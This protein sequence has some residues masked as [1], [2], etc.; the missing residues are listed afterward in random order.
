MFKTLMMVFLMTT[1]LCA[2]N[3]RTTT[4]V[5]GGISHGDYELTIGNHE[6]S[7]MPNQYGG[8]S[9]VTLWNAAASDDEG[10][11]YMPHMR[12]YEVRLKSKAGVRS[13]AK[14]VIDG[15]EVGVFRVEP[16]QTIVIERSLGDTARFTFIQKQTREY[17]AAKLDQVESG[18][19]GLISVTFTPERGYGQSVPANKPKI[20][21]PKRV[22]E[23]G[24]LKT[25]A[26]SGGTGLTGQSNQQFNYVQGIQYDQG[27]QVT[28]HLRLVPKETVEA[29]VLK[30]LEASKP[31]EAK[32]PAP[33]R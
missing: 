8:Y 11:V 30:P 7:L 27:R 16:N 12:Q 3:T 23:E 1:S 19:L 2:Q 14:V 25:S 15:K 9:E 33:R 26:R 20:E 22:A 18:K 29:P 13:D 10:Y 21:S 5:K 24:P 6:K 31:F 32:I 28:L 17:F 4:Y